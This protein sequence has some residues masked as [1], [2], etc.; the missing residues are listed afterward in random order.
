MLYTILYTILYIYNIYIYIYIYIYNIY[1][2]IYIYSIY[3][4]RMVSIPYITVYNKD[5]GSKR[6]A[7][8]KYI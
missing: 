4:I 2:Y 8:T 6:S 5:S 7:K 3:Y 1:I